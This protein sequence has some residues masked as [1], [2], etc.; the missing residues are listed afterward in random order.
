MLDYA[1]MILQKVSFDP[2]LFHKELIKSLKWLSEKE[3]NELKVWA[4]NKFGHT[5]DKTAF[6]N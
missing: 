4:I 2:H 6:D 3:K 1:K 5:I